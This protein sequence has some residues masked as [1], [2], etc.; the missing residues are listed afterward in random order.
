M[1]LPRAAGSR[2]P[3][4]AA[5]ARAAHGAAITHNH[6]LLA[7][8]RLLEMLGQAAPPQPPPPGAAAATDAPWSA[9]LQPAAA[10]AGGAS[11]TAARGE[12]HAAAA[13]AARNCALTRLLWRPLTSDASTRLLCMCSASELDL[14]A[15]LD[16]LALARNARL[17]RTRPRPN[18]RRPPPTMAAL[19]AMLQAVQA[20]LPAAEVAAAK[21]EPLLSA[22]S[23]ANPD[24]NPNPDPKPNPGPNPG[25]NPDPDPDPDPNPNQGAAGSRVRRVRGGAGTAPPS[26]E[27][28]LE[29]R[30]GGGR[31]QAAGETAARRRASP[32]P[33]RWRRHRLPVARERSA[34]ARLGLCT[35]RSSN[36]LVMKRYISVP[37]YSLLKCS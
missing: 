32:R 9:H 11:N 20:Q 36:T 10:G 14:P 18:R 22:S 19:A 23:Q 15:T 4:V 26:L 30:L 33:E 28:R 3:A 8:H 1:T 25:P 31:A 16:T 5:A 2:L 35:V 21:L 24:P 7:L 17:L 13:A 27:G 34:C 12:M 6:S 37:Y 29:G